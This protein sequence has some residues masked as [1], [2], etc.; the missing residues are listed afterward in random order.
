MAIAKGTPVIDL[1]DLDARMVHHTVRIA[2]ANRMGWLGPQLSVGAHVGTTIPTTLVQVVRRR[3]AVTLVRVGAR[4][5]GARAGVQLGTGRIVRPSGSRNEGIVADGLDHPVM[6]GFGPDGALYLT[7]PA[8]GP[9]M[10]ERQ[11]ALLRI[12][13]A[14]R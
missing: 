9:G 8:V 12:D 13:V 11:G 10:D 3:A 4:L 2:H 14:V 1:T 7:Y 6:L 5:L